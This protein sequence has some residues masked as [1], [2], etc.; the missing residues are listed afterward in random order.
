[1]AAKC[2]NARPAS[3]L[4]ETI[5]GILMLVAI[6]TIVFLSFVAPLVAAPTDQDRAASGHEASGVVAEWK[7]NLESIDQLLVAGK[8]NKAYKESSQLLRTMTDR[9]IE[10]EGAYPLMAAASVL[11]AVAESGRGNLGDAIFDLYLAKAFRA[12]VSQFDFSR[13]GEI[14]V[15]LTEADLLPP[16]GQGKKVEEPGVKPPKRTYSPTPD[17]P[18]AMKQACLQGRVIVATI[19]TKEGRVSHPQVLHSDG[20]PVMACAAFEAIRHWRFKPATVD[21]FDTDVYLNMTVNFRLPGC[22]QS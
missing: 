13:Y 20:G 9:I 17:Y 19:I 16:K 14:G 1:M 22:P 5:V 4:H 7:A 3:F 21:G 11:R 10:G 8:Y 18:G 2:E 6:S 15:P 12:D